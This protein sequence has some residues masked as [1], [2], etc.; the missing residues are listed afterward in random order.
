MSI[1]ILLLPG[2]GIGPEVAAEAELLIRSVAENYGLDIVM[3]S[4]LIGGAARV[5]RPRVRS[6]RPATGPT[7][8]CWVR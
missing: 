2:D 1:R 4:A 6:W 3:E 5:W 7:R 8:W